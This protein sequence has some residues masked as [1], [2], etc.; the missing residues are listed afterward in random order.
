[1]LRLDLRVKEWQHSLHT[2]MA[3]VLKKSEDRAGRQLGRSI[4][5]SS[6]TSDSREVSSG[7]HCLFIL[8]VNFRHFYAIAA[9]GSRRAETGPM[10]LKLFRPVQPRSRGER[11]RDLLE[12]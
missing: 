8:H 10:L 2:R 7:A 6:L 3:A 11:I 4:S 12:C 1:M 5:F 9:D